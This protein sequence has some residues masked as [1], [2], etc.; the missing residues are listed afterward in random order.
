MLA[1][2]WSSVVAYALTFF[3]HVLILQG[4]EKISL[5]ELILP[6]IKKHE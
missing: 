1:A 3:L 4:Y 5:K 2:A 6:I